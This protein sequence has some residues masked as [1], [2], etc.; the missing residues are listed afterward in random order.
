[1]SMKEEWRSVSIRCGGPFAEVQGGITG[2]ITAIGE[3]QM[4]ELSVD[5]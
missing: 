5:N 2:L 4:E 1:M 3:L